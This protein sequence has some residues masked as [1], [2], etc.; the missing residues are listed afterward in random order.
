MELCKKIYL[1]MSNGDSSTIYYDNLLPSLIL[2][3]SQNSTIDLSLVNSDL[4]NLQNCF[5]TC[6]RTIDIG[7]G[8]T[9]LN[10]T[11]GC[12]SVNATLS[13]PEEV[14]DHTILLKSY[15]ANFTYCTER[16]SGRVIHIDCVGFNPEDSVVH[17][18]IVLEI[19]HSG[20]C[21]DTYSLKFGT[22]ETG[23]SDCSTCSTFTV[24]YIQCPVWT[25]GA[26]K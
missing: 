18:R 14:M 24:F 6:T 23:K 1:S 26:R 15:K 9:S 21:I 17:E 10:Y 4:D 7:R 12:F 16:Q 20:V 19:S 22:P 13:P 11:K 5:K 3:E 2:E 25:E 8:L